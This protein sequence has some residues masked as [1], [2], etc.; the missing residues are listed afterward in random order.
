MISILYGDHSRSWKRWRI[1]IVRW[2][3]TLTICPVTIS[4]CF[5]DT[6]SYCAKDVYTTP[7]FNDPSWWQRQHFMTAVSCERTRMTE[8]SSGWRI[9]P[10]DTLACD[11]Q[12]D[13]QTKLWCRYR[14]WIS[15]RNARTSYKNASNFVEYSPHVLSDQT[16][17]KCWSF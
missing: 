2:H 9:Q 5:R 11:G 15:W 1:I 4:H 10:F 3:S 14:G 16:A 12:T 13:G 8:L 7:V 6:T 17:A